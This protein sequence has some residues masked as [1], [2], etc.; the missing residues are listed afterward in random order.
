[1]D[2]NIKFDDINVEGASN[3][4]TIKFYPAAP[5]SNGSITEDK[6]SPSVRE[7]LNSGGMSTG[8]KEALLSLLAKVAY[9]DEHGQ[10][11]LDILT[12]ELFN[13]YTVANNLSNVTNSN[14]E[15]TANEGGSYSAT[16]T[17]TE[18]VIRS[19]T[20]TMGGVDVTSQVFTGVEE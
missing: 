2:V 6:L 16:L 20:I 9:I 12:A 10:D 15:T 4:Q 13:V 7:K 11:Y 14:V 18:G 19:V 1:M 17:P 5:V 3:L 8:A